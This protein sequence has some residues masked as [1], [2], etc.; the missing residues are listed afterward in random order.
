MDTADSPI[1]LPSRRV[2]TCD[3]SPLRTSRSGEQLSGGGR[4]VRRA[5]SPQEGLHRGCSSSPT[6]GFACVFGERVRRRRAVAI[7]F[8]ASV[9]TSV[10]RRPLARDLETEEG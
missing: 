8:R 5:T 6:C 2:P 7:A 1:G 10:Y 3:L 4:P 9:A